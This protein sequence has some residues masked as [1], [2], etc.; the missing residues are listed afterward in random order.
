MNTYTI[1]WNSEPN[2]P[3]TFTGIAADI[4]GETFVITN[5]TGAGLHTKIIPL[6]NVRLI[7]EWAPHEQP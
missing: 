2:S 1:Y 6:R 3:E 7:N 4:Q 5:D